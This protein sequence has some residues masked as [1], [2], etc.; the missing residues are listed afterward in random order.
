[1][2]G[3]QR[4]RSLELGEYLAM[5]DGTG[6][7]RVFE[8]QIK[9]AGYDGRTGDRADNARVL[10]REAQK[11]DFGDGKRLSACLDRDLLSQVRGIP[12]SDHAPM[13][14]ERSCVLFQVR[15]DLPAW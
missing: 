10:G 5:K 3:A 9:I 14:A 13:N 1:L 4:K 11:L 2:T 6:G 8:A 7:Q 12:A 15:A